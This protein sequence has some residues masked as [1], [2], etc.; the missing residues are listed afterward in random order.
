MF[1]CFSRNVCLSVLKT[2]P[3]KT[4]QSC[5]WP[6]TIIFWQ[7]R[8][9]CHGDVKKAWTCRRC[10]FFWMLFILG[11]IDKVYKSSEQQSEANTS[12]C[13]MCYRCVC[14]CVRR[15]HRQP[16][17][18]AD[19]G[20]SIRSASWRYGR[21]SADETVDLEFFSPTNKISKYILI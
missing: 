11:Y 6:N 19:T 4:D 16:T 12:T 2:I 18:A 3:E 21:T 14:V 1:W 17:A 10:S 15:R 13:E 8:L 20:L 7:V 9:C 5:V